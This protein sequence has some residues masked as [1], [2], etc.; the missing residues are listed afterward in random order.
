MTSRPAW[1]C[2]VLGLWAVWPL[3]A[4]ARV[5]RILV[6]NRDNRIVLQAGASAPGLLQLAR[7]GGAA[8]EGDAAAVLI[9][10]AGI[11]GREV[12]LH[13][14][15]D[16]DA[17][18]QRED[19]ASLV[20]EDRAAGLRLYWE[21]RARASHGPLEHVIRIENRSG[22]RVWL[23]LQPSLQFAWKVAADQPLSQVWVDKGAGE[24]PPVGTHRVAIAAHY[25]WRG[26]SS[27]FAHPRPGEAREIIPWFLVSGEGAGGWYVGV[28]FSGRVAM[29]LKRTGAVLAGT[30][31]LNP[32]PGP[33]RTRLEPGATLAT[34][35]VFVGAS[36]GD[37]D[38]TGNTLRRWV[39][40]VLGDPA[41]RADPAYPLVTNNSWG[42]AMAIDEAQAR[43]MID[44][45]ARLGFEMFHLDAGWFRAVGDWHADP[46]KFP[47]GIAAL[48]DYAHRR[49]LRFGLWAAW[50]QA[51]TSPARGALDVADPT[52]RDWLTT[53]PPPGWKPT[54]FKGVT[55]DLGVPAA[56]AWA[57][58]E[59]DRLVREYHLDMLEHDGYIVAQ[60]CDR[61]DHPHAAA[62]PGRIRRYSD[63]D[64]LW[65]DAANATDVSLHATRAYYAVQ[66]ALRRRHP[67]LLLEV[68]NDGG[69][70]VDFGSAAYGDYFSIVDSYDPLS[71]R[72]AFYD[73]SHVLPPAM[74]ETYVKAW[75]TPRIENFRYMLRSGMMGWFTVMIDTHGWTPAQHAA[76]AR[77][78]A[79]YQ[80]ALRPLIRDAGLYHVGPRP[81]GK[82]WD[83]TEYFDGARDQGVV[84][85]FHGSDP[86]PRVFRFKLRGLR[87][88]QRYRVHFRDHSSPDRVLDG[89]AL[90]A[91]GLAVTLPTPESSELVVIEGVR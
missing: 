56:Q 31:G 53:D 49:G 48:S 67:G 54:G 21:W 18:R 35:T 33:F 36:D 44:D 82:G 74:L 1:T 7:Q 16:P 52:V 23:P 91:S 89:R 9:G 27:T 8:W 71:N 58:G 59:T 70:M 65:V 87:T 85:A 46:H 40:E 63:D 73:A 38:D 75:P 14:R 81:D 29:N 45:A 11:G 57:T 61:H 34:P 6:G 72:Q 37:P 20:Y 47:H 55:I 62:D 25:D 13:W 4:P 43:R 69:R 15:Y 68:C 30:V 2:L 64:F 24:P 26:T 51:G 83:G 39:R 42:S 76:A 88:G 12:P 90:M 32:V 41:T 86:A 80:S 5:A 19:A 78:I 28:E 60:G 22:R 79:F 10:H 77:E 84:F 66:Q 3:A 50:A 17:S